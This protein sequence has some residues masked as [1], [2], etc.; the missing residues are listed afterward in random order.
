MIYQLAAIVRDV[1]ICLDQNQR[2]GQLLE[3]GERDTLSLDTI[4]ISKV[5]E[6]VERVESVAPAHLLEEGHTFGDSVVWG[7]KESGRVM[8]PDDFMRLVA[9]RMSDWERT[10][11]S[12]ISADTGEYAKQSSRYKGIRGNVQ[13]PVCAIVNGAS[14]K[15]LEFYSCNSEEA[16]VSRGSYIPYP[17]IDENGGIDISERCYIAVVYT[18]ASLVLTTYG[19]REQ[20]NE[21]AEKAQTILR[22]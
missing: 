19:E 18:I 8:L 2:D 16:Y 17:R 5:E 13:R 4:I 21:L 9:F 22:V 7:E 10:L 1:R 6:A 14:G 20:S 3:T 11:Y 12:A 15:E